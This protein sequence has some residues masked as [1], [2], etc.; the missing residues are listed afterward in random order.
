MHLWLLF[1][2]VALFLWG[3][4]GVTQKLSTNRITSERSFLWFC[5]AMVALSAVVMFAVHLQWGL[6]RLVLLSAIAGGALNGIGAWTSFRALESGGKA[7]IVI[8][9]VSLYPLLTVLLAVLILGE[10]LT[11]LQTMGAFT[12][13][14]AAILL[15]VETSA[16]A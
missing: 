11:G 2:I 7:S 13:I 4:T 14:A 1:S 8:S 9:L 5:W 15:S 6:S 16:Q 10:R 3:I 12:A